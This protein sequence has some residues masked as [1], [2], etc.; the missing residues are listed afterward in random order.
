[1]TS[2]RGGGELSWCLEIPRALIKESVLPVVL[3]FSPPR[4]GLKNKGLFP[5][6][7]SQLQPSLQFRMPT[8]MLIRELSC[9][10]TSVDL[11]KVDMHDDQ[12]N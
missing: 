1:M 12:D 10:K 6:L 3:L 4:T 8:Q 9:I 7:D 2:R 11:S 5:W